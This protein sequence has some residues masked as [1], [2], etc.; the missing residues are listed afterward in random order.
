MTNNL[1]CPK[2]KLPSLAK[3][4][5]KWAR[6]NFD[7]TKKTK[8]QQYICNS[9]GRITIHP[10]IPQPRDRSGRFTSIKPS[11]IDSNAS[12]TGNK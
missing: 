4:G 10:L 12:K 5:L 7:N 1:R 6:D 3:F 9:C 2:C 11:V 8:H